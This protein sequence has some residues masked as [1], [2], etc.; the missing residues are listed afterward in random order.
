MKHK[1]V[2]YPLLLSLLAGAFQSLTP[3]QASESSTADSTEEVLQY[4]KAGTK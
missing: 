4:S 1:I 3:I 2:T